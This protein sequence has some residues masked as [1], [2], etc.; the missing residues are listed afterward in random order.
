[1]GKV[2]NL[3]VGPA[4]A[5]VVLGMVFESQLVGELLT[6]VT[7]VR[8]QSMHVEVGVFVELVVECSRHAIAGTV[9]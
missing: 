3:Q 5:G 2:C 6:V 7:E 4:N 1:M 8:E 9:I